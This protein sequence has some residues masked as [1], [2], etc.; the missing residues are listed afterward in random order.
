MIRHSSAE[1]VEITLHLIS[2]LLSGE[3]AMNTEQHILLCDILPKL[4]ELRH[5]AVSDTIRV[6]AGEIFAK[7]TTPQSIKGESENPSACS[8]QIPV[9]LQVV[10]FV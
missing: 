6:T 8:E 9:H 10:Y 3:H 4:D 5:S 2:A 1:V 7:L